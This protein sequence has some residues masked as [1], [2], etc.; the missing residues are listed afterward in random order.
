MNKNWAQK[1][2]LIPSFHFLQ[3]Y[4]ILVLYFRNLPRKTT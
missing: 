4:Y 1:Y 3:L 2:N